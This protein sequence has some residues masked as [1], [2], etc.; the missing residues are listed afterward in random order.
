M[1]TPKPKRHPAD[2]TRMPARYFAVLCDLLKARGI[3][4]EAMLKAAKIWPTQIYGPDATLTLRQLEALLAETSLTTRRE[5]L[6]FEL[7]RQIKLSTHEILGYGILTSPTLDYALQLA[8]RYWRLIT[9]AF[10]LR[11]RRD[12]MHSE[13][14]FQPAM[15]L[16]AEAL[17]FMLEVIVVSAHE[18][19]KALT[20][21]RLPSYDIYVSYAE[22]G[23]AR[24]YRALKPARFHFGSE[25][26]PS[27]RLVLDA[28]VA[29][30]GLPMADRAALK[31]AEG[32][33][34]ELLRRTAQ[35]RGMTEWV[36]MM[37]REAHEGMPSLAELARLMNQSSRTLDRQLTREGGK[38]LELSKR[39]R[40]DKACELLRA[41]NLSVTQV[42]L[43]VGYRDL[44]NFTRAF[45]RESG[46]SP[47]QYLRD[48]GVADNP[49]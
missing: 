30:H 27:A 37:L 25:R 2:A 15:E 5:D 24:A 46:M 35:S 12:R 38:F 14:H 36:T 23:H 32:R 4:I 17:R 45:K 20:Q 42:A 8:A 39:I 9:P 33:C 40:H 44:A 10:T 7:G 11:Y 18:Q 19:L 31:M 21:A 26:L 29:A 41:G 16:S 47:T 34:E 43:K 13:L 6:G 48:V 49:V 1:Q 28:E 22:P 3:D